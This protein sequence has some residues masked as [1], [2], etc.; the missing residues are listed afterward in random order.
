MSDEEIA[1]SAAVADWVVAQPWSSG[2]IGTT[3]ISYVG[4]LAELALLTRHPAFKASVPL[5]PSHDS[6]A[7]LYFPGGM[8]NILHSEA[9]AR[10]TAEMDKAAPGEIKSYPE[11]V[12]P[13][14][15]D[16]DA[17]GKLLAAARAEHQANSNRGRELQGV[18]FRDEVQ[19]PQGKWSGAYRLRTELDAADVPMMV[20]AGWHDSAFGDGA[21]NRFLTSRSAHK[22]L[23]LAPTSH[24][25]DYFYGPG[26]EVTT[27]S[28]FDV[29]AE[30]LRFFDQYLGDR[31]GPEHSAPHL[32]WFVSGANAWREADRWPG[33]TEHR[34]FCLAEGRLDATCREPKRSLEIAPADV[35]STPNG[36]WHTSMGKPVVYPDRAA[37]DTALPRFETLPLE[38]DLEIFGSPM[39][40]L[41]LRTTGRDADV[42]AYL[43]EVQPSGR[44][45][46][47]TEGLLR[48]SHARPGALP[49]RSSALN[50]VTSA[51][52]SSA[53]GTGISSSK[54]V[55]SPWRTASKR[56]AG[57]AWCSPDP[58]SRCLTP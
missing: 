36:R 23:V 44:A 27:H 5:Y 35:Q 49:Y 26:T 6:F 57:C 43:E 52:T 55:S 18:R 51:R 48:A 39:L 24:G 46:Y 14:P 34:R 1:D 28:S 54:S 53:C 29:K 33:R 22:W 4:A 2:R 31:S 58:M 13:C 9:W 7:D 21:I 41:A 10:V 25:G 3:G 37:K 47:V 56:E 8:K 15:V 12:G 30:M 40:S 32:R 16:D 38:Q 19:M 17:D 42:V 20:I 50:A 11:V 45:F